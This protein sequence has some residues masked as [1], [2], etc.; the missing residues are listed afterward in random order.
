MAG[1]RIFPRNCRKIALLQPRQPSALADIETH[2]EIIDIQ[3][4][5]RLCWR[6][7]GRAL[8]DLRVQSRLA[9]VV[10]VWL[11]WTIG[12]ILR[13]ALLLTL[14]LALQHRISAVLAIDWCLRRLLADW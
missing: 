9:I 13:L 5:G 2:R 11:L 3:W 12:P 6:H 7:I 4:V 1:L 10:V 14:S 8:D